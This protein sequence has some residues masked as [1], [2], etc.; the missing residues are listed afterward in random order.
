M[1]KYV[2]QIS[3]LQKQQK[4][5]CWPEDHPHQD[6]NFRFQ[7]ASYGKS[8]MLSLHDMKTVISDGN[9]RIESN[10]TDL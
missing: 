4:V 5:Y 8:C 10:T 1:G 3:R 7:D 2:A 9:I 6:V